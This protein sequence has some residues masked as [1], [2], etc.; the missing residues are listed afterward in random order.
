M[1][2]TACESGNLGTVPSSEYRI[3][4]TADPLW[5]GFSCT[6]NNG[7]CAQIGM[8]WFHRKLS[9][10]ADAE[11]EVRICKTADHNNEDIALEKLQL[12]VM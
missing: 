9:M 2:F 6:T 3:Y 7:C 1:T 12:Y 4:Y 5:D 10:N 11:I 8:P